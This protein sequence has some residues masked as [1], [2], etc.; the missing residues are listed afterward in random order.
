MISSRQA[1]IIYFT[2]QQNVS[3]SAVSFNFKRR[4]VAILGL[5]NVFLFQV[6][7]LVSVDGS[8]VSGQFPVLF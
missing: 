6:L 8:I 1:E 4:D 5:K 2:L 3:G 7:H